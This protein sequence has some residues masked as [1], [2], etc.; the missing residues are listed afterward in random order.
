LS[1]YCNVSKFWEED[2]TTDTGSK[3]KIK[4]LLIKLTAGRKIKQLQSSCQATL[5]SNGKKS[6]T[7]QKGK[8]NHME[9]SR[10]PG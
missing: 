6:K 7:N 3:S 5:S 4:H 10:I 9:Q 1:L 2:S 8:Q